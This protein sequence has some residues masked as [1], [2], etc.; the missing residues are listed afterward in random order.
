VL[1]VPVGQKLDTP[2]F[3]GTLESLSLGNSDDVDERSLGGEISDGQLF[4]E[5]PFGVGKSLCDGTSADPQLHEL[6]DLLGHSADELGLGVCENAYVLGVQT[7]IPGERFGRVLL[8]NPHLPF[9]KGVQVIGPYFASGLKAER[10]VL[11]ESYSG[12]LHGGYLDNGYRSLNLHSGCRALCALID[13]ECMRHPGLV[14]RESLYLG[15]PADLWPRVQPRPLCLRS[16]PGA[17]CPGSSLRTSP[18]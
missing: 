18:L 7:V 13:D 2:T 17:K 12:Y 11:I 8:G 15:G 5:D 4:S 6:W 1:A 10:A 3:G 9:E 16:L 14:T